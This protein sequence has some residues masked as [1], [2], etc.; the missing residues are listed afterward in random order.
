MSLTYSG[1]DHVGSYSAH[2]ASGRLVICEPDDR[3]SDPGD[4]DMLATVGSASARQ[5]QAGGLS[6][7][8]MS[9]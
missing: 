2:C 9:G 6:I 4:G 8:T 1:T 5:R 7:G 3:H